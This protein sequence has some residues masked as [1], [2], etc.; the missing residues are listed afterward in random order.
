MANKIDELKD[1]IYRAFAAPRTPWYGSDI[2]A[3]VRDYIEE[4][5]RLKVLEE[6]I[7]DNVKDDIKKLQER[8]KEL[9]LAKTMGIQACDLLNERIKELEEIINYAIGGIDILSKS[10]SD[11]QVRKDILAVKETLDKAMKEGD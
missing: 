4:V 5:E 10:W 9:E 3:W 11:K 7:S 2:E 8:I 6:V 1:K